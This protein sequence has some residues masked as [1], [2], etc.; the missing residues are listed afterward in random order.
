[1]LQTNESSLLFDSNGR[2]IP[3]SIKNEIS[4]LQIGEISFDQIKFKAPVFN[5]NRIEDY[6]IAWKYFEKV[7]AG[8][9]INT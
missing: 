3:S 7:F 5:C 9:E 6:K 8:Q 4:G 1:V 2:I